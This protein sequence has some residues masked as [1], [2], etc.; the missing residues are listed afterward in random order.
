MQLELAR[1]LK[2]LYL[3]LLRIYN[4]VTIEIV[5]LI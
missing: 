5:L 1:W 2:Y 3:Y 4:E